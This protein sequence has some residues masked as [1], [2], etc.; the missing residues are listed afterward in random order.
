MIVDKNKWFYNE[1]AY[2]WFLANYK[3]ILSNNVNRTFKHLTTKV[4]VFSLPHYFKFFNVCYDKYKE[5]LKGAI[6][7]D[8]YK[9]EQLDGLFRTFKPNIFKKFYHFC[10]NI[11]YKIVI[12]YQFTRYLKQD[13]LFRHTIDKT[14][15]CKNI[16]FSYALKFISYKAYIKPIL[17][18]HSNYTLDCIMNL[19]KYKERA[20][21]IRDLRKGYSVQFKNYRLSLITP[22]DWQDNGIF[23]IYNITSKLNYYFIY[24]S[25]SINWINETFVKENKTKEPICYD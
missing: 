12:L 1:I 2:G 4:I 15:Y 7:Y 16:D 19:C 17:F 5:G 23:K 13:Y 9:K 18:F 3:S 24:P 6:V 11:D 25:K 14:E 22:Y 10:Q 20:Y 8:T 21:L